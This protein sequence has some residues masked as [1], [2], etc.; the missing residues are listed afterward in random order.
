[1]QQVKI[2]LPFLENLLFLLELLLALFLSFV[3]MVCLAFYIPNTYS[4]HQT[5]ARTI[6]LNEVKTPGSF[7]FTF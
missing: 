2:T 3:L 1:M 6:K 4:P 7:S 5:L